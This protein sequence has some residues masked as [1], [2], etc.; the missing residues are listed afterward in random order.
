MPRIIPPR[1]LPL[2]L[3]RFFVVDFTPPLAHQGLH[4]SLDCAT[5]DA[6]CTPSCILG[7]SVNNGF[8]HN[9]AR[10]PAARVTG[11]ALA[12]L[13]LVCGAFLLTSCGH[14]P[15]KAT[16]PAQTETQNTNAASTSTNKEAASAEEGNVDKAADEKASQDD[17]AK[18]AKHQGAYAIAIRNGG[19]ADGLAGAARGKTR[20]SRPHR[21]QSHL[22]T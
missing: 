2:T 22:R 17:S 4:T 8:T 14:E 19:G 20:C 18:A 7:G 13:L 5:I 10:I 21:R 15:E 16:P 6:L 1:R 12:T 3:G 9:Q 11:F